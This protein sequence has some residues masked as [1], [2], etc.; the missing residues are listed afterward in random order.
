M[1]I[2]KFRFSYT[3][4]SPEAQKLLEFGSLEV[5]NW[6]F[7]GDLFFCS[8]Y[9]KNWWIV[10]PFNPSQPPLHKSHSCENLHQ[11]PLHFDTS[12]EAFFF[13]FGNFLGCTVPIRLWASF[14]TCF[15]LN[16]ES[17][18]FSSHPNVYSTTKEK[19]MK[20]IDQEL[21]TKLFHTT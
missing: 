12:L 4:F 17:F 11:H 14:Y 19:E 18:G 2:T 7:S 8:I 3:I 6:N 20:M 15:I 10:V 21:K 1:H 13:Y 9:L 5:E 16:F